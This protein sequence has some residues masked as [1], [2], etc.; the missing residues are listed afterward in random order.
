MNKHICCLPSSI[1]IP[2]VLIPQYINVHAQISIQTFWNYYKLKLNDLYAVCS[3]FIPTQK[4]SRTNLYNS[5]ILNSFQNK[6]TN[7]IVTTG[8]LYGFH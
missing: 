6:I 4:I 7:L 3:M 8:I 1:F 5:P 2:I